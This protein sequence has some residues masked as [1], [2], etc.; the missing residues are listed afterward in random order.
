VIAGNWGDVVQRSG[1]KWNIIS[2]NDYAITNQS[3]KNR[4]RMSHISLQPMR[5]Y[6]YRSISSIN[7]NKLNGMIAE[8][9]LRKKFGELGFSNRISPGGWIVRN[10]GAN[11]FGRHTS[12]FFPETIRINIEYPDNRKFEEPP[13]GLHTICATMHQIGIYSFY[14][15]PAIQK[16]EDPYSIKWYS[17]QLGIPT[18]DTYHE[19]PNNIGNFSSRS[20]KYNFLQ[21][22]SNSALIPEEAVPE[23]FSKEHIRVSFQNKYMSEM[24]DIDGIFWGQQYTYPIEIKEK[25]ADESSK[26]GEYFGIDVGPFVKLAFYAAKRGNLHSLF[27]VRE[28]DNTTDRQLLNW[29]FI[30]FERLARFVSWVPVAGGKNMRGGGSSV[31]RIPKSEF[32]PLTKANLEVL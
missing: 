5:E 31:I 7:Q 22:K 13:R 6:L 26:M 12:V 28:I 16:D 4:K 11:A 2:G 3:G 24:S 23:E 25:T 27:I 8:I 9:D 14:C 19:F 20:R 15:V 10:V 32:S 18:Q 21:Y 30:P 17:T 29:W 1:I